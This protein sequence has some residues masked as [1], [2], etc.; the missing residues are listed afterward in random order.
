MEK[1]FF[2]IHSGN[3]RE[4]PGDFASTQKAFVL[5]ADLSAKPAIMDIGCGP[6]KQTLDLLT[7]TEG[8][9]IAVD[10]HQPYIDRLNEQAA[11]RGLQD[12]V[13]AVNG[14][15][16]HLDFNAESFDV[17]WSEG[18]IYIIG[19]EKGLKTWR[20]LLKKKGYLAVTEAT[21]LKAGP[22]DTLN[23]FW[24]EGYPGMQD[25]QGNLSTIKRCGYV[26][27]DH[28]T[29][30]ESAWWDD[31]YNSILKRLKAL[32]EK[33]KDIAAA[34]EVIEAEKIEIDLYREYSEYYGYVF[35]VMQRM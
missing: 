27:I 34:L 28:F 20:P 30:P 6:G 32:E 21:W 11:D 4:G 7:L 14:D 29:L 5:M 31:Y 26:L 17:I 33:Y 8:T 15:M 24:A 16:F 13:T 22:P 35:Y 2:E 10:N 3:P 1:V 9:V 12:R 23:K 25:I 18:A 19:F